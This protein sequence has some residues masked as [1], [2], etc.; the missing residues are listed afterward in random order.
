M[1]IVEFEGQQYDFPEDASQ[2]EI[3]QTLSSLPKEEEEVV[4]EDV[5]EPFA[6]QSV[7]KKD[8]GIKR[9]KE[10][11]HVAYKDSKGIP[12]GGVGHLLTDDERKLYPKGTAIPDEVVKQWFKTDM[13]EADTSLT[14]VLEDKA[15][16]VPDDVYS[17]LLNMTFNL[18]EGGILEFTD[19]W[20]A[21]EVG[22]WKTAAAEMRDSKWAKDV[23]NRAVRLIRR[24]D[25]LA[26]KSETTATEDL[27]E[28]ALSQGVDLTSF[29]DG[30]YEDVNGNRIIIKD[31]RVL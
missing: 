2:E 16:R 13:D 3:T 30:T 27:N 21:I 23:G 24:M 1:P 9:N 17:I 28:Q 10:G 14:R 5:R 6:E 12:T 22:D 19:M 18:G 20:A 7:I 31:G 25:S 4:A 11:S 8:E 29:E 15:V 26:V